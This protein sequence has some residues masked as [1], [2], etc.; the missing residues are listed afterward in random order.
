MKPID[1]WADGSK[2]QGW[3]PT[4]AVAKYLIDNKQKGGEVLLTPSCFYQFCMELGSLKGTVYPYADGGIRFA[5]P[6]GW[7]I[8]KPGYDE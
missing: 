2:Y 4:E 5:G 8:V 1:F 7:V 3:A 6:L